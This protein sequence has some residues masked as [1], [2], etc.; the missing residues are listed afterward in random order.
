VRARLSRLDDPSNPFLLPGIEV[1][2]TTTDRF[3]LEQ[4]QL[5]R[6]TGGRWRASGGLW[7]T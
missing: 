7:G 5:L 4:A 1:E 6:F 2:T 3:L